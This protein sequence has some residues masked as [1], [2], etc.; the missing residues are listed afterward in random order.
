MH[1][2]HGLVPDNVHAWW[3]RRWCRAQKAELC[4]GRRVL[5]LYRPSFTTPAACSLELRL[6]L[7]SFSP[8]PPSLP[9]ASLSLHTLTAYSAIN[10]SSLFVPPATLRDVPRSDAAEAYPKDHSALIV[11]ATDTAPAYDMSYAALAAAV[12]VVGRQLMSLLPTGKDEQVGVGIGVGRGTR[13]GSGRQE[14]MNSAPADGLDRRP[15]S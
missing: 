11:P 14:V 5:S 7:S 9:H 10:M 2:A 4:V 15:I 3:R 1:A 13:S 8:L 12:T 6:I